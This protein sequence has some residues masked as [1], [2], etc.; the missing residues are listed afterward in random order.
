MTLSGVFCQEARENFIV[1]TTIAME[2]WSKMK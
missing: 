2:Y 1:D